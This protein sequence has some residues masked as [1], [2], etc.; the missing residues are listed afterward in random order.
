MAACTSFKVKAW[1]GGCMAVAEGAEGRVRAFIDVITDGVTAQVQDV[2]GLSPQL[3]RQVE[4]DQAAPLA[5]VY[6][7]FL[8][9]AGGGA[10]RFLQGSDVFH[11]HVLGLWAA[12]AELLKDNQSEFVLQD[13]DRV[14][15]MHQG[16]QF[17]FLR[18][19]GPDP[20]V[21]SYCEVNSPGNAPK[22][23]HERFS[24][25]LMDNAQEQTKAWIQLANLI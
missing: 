8:T 22:R 23:S 17:D 15:F 1:T 3:V 19:G 25:W 7:W 11:P 10:G 13:T 18:G 20:E 5:D 4:E 9:L 14:F 2:K 12:A 21:W 6:R 16:Y 24:D